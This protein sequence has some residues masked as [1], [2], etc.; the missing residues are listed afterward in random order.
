M[1][2]FTKSA[3]SEIL[4]HQVVT[5]PTIVEGT[6]T[7]VSDD[8]ACSLIMFFAGVEAA[9]N[10]NPGSFE[11][12]ISTATSGDESWAT[13]ATFTTSSTT[14]ANDNLN[15]GGEAQGQ[16]VIGV[17]DTTGYTA[18][19]WTYLQDT[20][21]LADSEW[22]QLVSVQAGTSLTLLDGIAN[23]KDDNDDSWTIAEVF[24]MT[25][26]LTGVNRIRVNFVHVG[27]TGANAHVKA[28]MCKTTDIE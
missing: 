18:G 9:A 2:D 26:D 23:A 3:E 6:A 11:V 24:A 25:L 22:G 15:S 14:P 1:A 8:L 21:T 10:T 16:T 4:S 20:G 13:V 19:N 5:H 7:S 17:D 27:T 28:V 12:Q